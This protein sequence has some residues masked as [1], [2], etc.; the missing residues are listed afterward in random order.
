M[1]VRAIEKIYYGGRDRRPGDEY[2]MDDRED[3]QIN[4]LCLLGKIERTKSADP[5]KRPR[6]EERPQKPSEPE[7]PPEP[8]KSTATSPMTTGS[9]L[10]ENPRRYKRRDMRAER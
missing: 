1:R 2:E 6:E 7:K 4:V 5:P 3:V 8:E 9:G 10:S